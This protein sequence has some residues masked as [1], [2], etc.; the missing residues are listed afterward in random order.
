MQA[1]ASPPPALD[2]RTCGACGASVHR[3]DVHKNRY[4]QYI[5]N[6]CRADGVRAVGR[7]RLRHMVQRMPT[8]LFAFLIV[9]LVLVLVPLAFFL[10][11]QLHSYSNTGMVGDLKAMV[12]S[13]NQMAR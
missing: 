11:T 2:H 6:N 3:A 13:I 9:V 4:G 1:P 7:Q 12:R 10:L 8:A 5:C